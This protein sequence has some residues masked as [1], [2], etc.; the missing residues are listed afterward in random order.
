VRFI[1]NKTGRRVVSV[2]DCLDADGYRFALADGNFV[3]VSMHDI[4]CIES[5]F[6][7]QGRMSRNQFEEMVMQEQDIDFPRSPSDVYP[8]FCDGTVRCDGTIHGA[9]FDMCVEDELG[10]APELDSERFHRSLRKVY[11]HRY[12]KKHEQK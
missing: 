8:E 1:E 5:D 6:C 4:E 2:E 9:E 12:L 7:E 10:E 3:I 11:W